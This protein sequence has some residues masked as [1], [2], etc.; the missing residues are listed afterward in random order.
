MKVTKFLYLLIFSSIFIFNACKTK[1]QGFEGRVIY[2]SS[3]ERPTNSN[4]PD[5]I[6][7]MMFNDVVDTNEITTFYIKKDFFKMVTNGKHT[8]TVLYDPELKRNYVY[9]KE[10]PDFCMWSEV[11]SDN[12]PLPKITKNLNDTII[13]LDKK[14]YSITIDY[15]AISKNILY[16][17]IDIMIDLKELENNK[18]GL[19]GYFSKIETMPYKIIMTGNGAVHNLGY[20]LKEIVNENLDDSI[21]KVP[22][23]K[24]MMKSP[25]FQK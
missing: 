11:T 2:K 15:G 1:S 18:L 16:Y 7:K 22:K 23:F 25:F 24:N 14:C 20:T 8:S 3:I 12:Q 21:F 9:M 6:F 4:I 19:M 10:Q 17:P 5:S 13:V